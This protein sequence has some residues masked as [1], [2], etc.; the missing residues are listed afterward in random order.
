M[1]VATSMYDRSAQLQQLNHTSAT[2]PYHQPPA[3]GGG[4]VSSAMSAASDIH[5]RDKELIYGYV[6]GELSSDLHVILDVSLAFQLRFFS[7][8]LSLSPSH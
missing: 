6:P 8:R 2:S 1:D 4:G 7:D 3:G 5:K